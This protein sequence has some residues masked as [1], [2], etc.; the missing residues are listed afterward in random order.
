MSRALIK[1]ILRSIKRSLSRFISIIAIV[2]LG[3]CFFAGINAVSPDMRATADKYFN[4]KK[5]MD[6]NVVSTIGLTDSDA[7]EI[8]GIDGVEAVMPS[9]TVDALV[10]IDGKGL[11]GVDGSVFSCRAY[12]IDPNAFLEGG[13]NESYL[14][15]L[16]LVE[17]RYPQKINE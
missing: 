6:I 9:K 7:W 11:L 14:N 1:E 4:E 16:T 10:S 15:R 3:T 2:A 13:V 12:S 5:L 8:S 17:G